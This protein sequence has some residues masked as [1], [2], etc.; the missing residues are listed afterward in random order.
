MRGLSLLL[1]LTGTIAGY[2]AWRGLAALIPA[3]PNTASMAVRIGQ[4][5]ASLLPAAGVLAAMILTQM[6]VR[7]WQGKFDP[8][9]GKDGRYLIVNQRVISNTVEQMAVFAPAMLALAAGA[10]SSRMA[11]VLAVP[12]VFALA[13]LVFWAG[14][15][16]APVLRAPGMAASFLACLAALGA[17][18]AVWVD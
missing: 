2:L 9:A 14:Y 15:L 18:V 6:A 13:R 7:F 5:A 16:T 10:P 1:A 4:G 3:D 11:E 8:T 17:A 12:L